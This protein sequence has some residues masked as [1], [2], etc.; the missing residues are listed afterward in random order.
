[1]TG[2]YWYYT[3]W[4]YCPVCGKT[5]TYRERKYGYRPK[6]WKNRN[7]EIEDYDYCNSL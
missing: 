1:M 5:D 2:K 7:K 6:L 3:T 4:Y